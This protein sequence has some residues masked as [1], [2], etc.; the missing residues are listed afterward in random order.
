MTTF[1]TFRDQIDR[2][3]PPWL[4]NTIGAKYLYSIGVQLDI[5]G[6]Q[7]Q[8]G[9]KRRFPQSAAKALDADALALIGLDRRIPRGPSET[10]AAYALRLVRAIDD[11]K[12]AGSCFSLIRQLQG[13]I[14]PSTT[15]IRI[16][17]NAGG[18]FTIDAAGVQSTFQSSPNNW[19]WDGNAAAWSRMWVIIYTAS[20]WPVEGTFGDGAT[21]GDGGALGT[22]ASL[23]TIAAIQSIISVWKAAH[24]TTVFVIF[25]DDP[26]SL[27]PFY[28][29]GPPMPDGTWGTW[30]T[31]TVSA[32]VA[33]R[34]QTARYVDAVPT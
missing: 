28:A 22:T 4:R 19:N 27:N 3:S 13:F 5:L 24:A 25:A 9:I 12:Q 7:V 14:S 31:N 26:N 15:T 18:W 2:I 34:L 21:Y 6:D 11:W 1:S 8:Q 20:I 17:N 16:V 33:S 29:V 32:S 30:A 10:L 23:A